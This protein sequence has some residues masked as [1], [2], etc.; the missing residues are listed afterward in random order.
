MHSCIQRWA[1][2]ESLLICSLS[3]FLLAAWFSARIRTWSS[4]SDLH[5]ILTLPFGRDFFSRYS[6]KS[7]ETPDPAL[8]RA[9]R[10]QNTIFRLSQGRGKKKLVT[11]SLLKVW[12]ADQR[13]RVTG[14]FL[15]KRFPGST[16]DLV[17]Q[18]V[19]LDK[20][21]RWLAH[22][23][24]GKH[25][26]TAPV[27]ASPCGV[28]VAQYHGLWGVPTRGLKLNVNLHSWYYKGHL[29]TEHRFPQPPKSTHMH[30]STYVH[31]STL[32]TTKLVK[33]LH[34]WVLLERFS[35]LKHKALYPEG[36]LKHPTE[37]QRFI[38]KQHVVLPQD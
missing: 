16:P 32:P 19:R 38:H 3:L 22:S 29:T 37:T 2:S 25:C 9:S 6:I 31:L 17:H 21:P 13:H 14:S 4:T 36:P 35:L 30:A 26:S 15:L 10:I 23:S 28:N 12:S 8:L 34:L 1:L 33:V 27:P 18:K 5:R 7:R 11:I 24:F 20:R